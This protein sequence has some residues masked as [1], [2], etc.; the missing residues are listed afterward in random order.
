L[1]IILVSNVLSDLENVARELTETYNVETSVIHVDF[2]SG[3]EIFEKIKQRIVD[4]EIGILVNNVGMMYQ[5]PDFFLNIPKREQVIQD[6][7]ACNVT[8]TPMMCSAV[9]PQMVQ[10]KRGLIIN[11]SSF[12][13][14]FPFPCYAVYAATKAFVNKF[15][16]DLAAEYDDKGI[17]I[18]SIMPGIVCK[19]KLVSLKLSCIKLSHHYSH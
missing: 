15:T 17:I 8:T 3:P 6:I 16:T 19:F 10:R 1:N 7:I 14:A 11:I 4:K 12:T 13:S 5:A 18:Q 9:L 2:R